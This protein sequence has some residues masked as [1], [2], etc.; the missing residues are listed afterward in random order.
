[1][2]LPGPEE[3]LRIQH[4][5][6]ISFYD[7]NTKLLIA[8][9]VFGSFGKNT[10]IYPASGY[11]I[12]SLEFE[13]PAGGFN[14]YNSAIA[15]VVESLCDNSEAPCCDQLPTQS[16]LDT[17]DICLPLDDFYTDKQINRR[18]TTTIPPLGI[19]CS[20]LNAQSVPLKYIPENTDVHT[21]R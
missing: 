16:I 9:N 4:S 21:R 10:Y 15:L 13:L 6:R 11:T 20:Y 12:P 14:F 7:F 5:V 2:F 19:P 8:S 3:W 18:T 17:D 1:M